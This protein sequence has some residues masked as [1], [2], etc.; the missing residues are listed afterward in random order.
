MPDARRALVPLL[1]GCGGS[2][3]DNPVDDSDA[4]SV[5]IECVD[6][7]QIEAPF[8]KTSDQSSGFE[9][10][11]TAD[12]PSEG[13]INRVAAVTC[14]ADPAGFHVACDAHKAEGSTCSEHAD[15]G[16]GGFCE[17]DWN[18]G[19]LC[20]CI[21]LCTKDGDCDA[22][23]AC[24]CAGTLKFDG[25]AVGTGGYGQCFPAGC[26]SPADCGGND[27]GLSVAPCHGPTGTYCRDD[28]DACHSDADCDGTYCARYSAADT[29]ACTPTMTCE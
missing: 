17:I 29:W 26:L 7:P 22:G 10:C 23:D 25:Y 6:I 18:K 9:Y 2:G 15:C 1:L 20:G 4:T 3:G 5:P 8:G 28:A 11:Y 14:V 24:V 13:F 19:G 12:A 16:P 27:C 21:Q